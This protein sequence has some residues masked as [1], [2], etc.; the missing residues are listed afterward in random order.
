MDIEQAIDLSK[1]FLKIDTENLEPYLA[2]QAHLFF[3]FTVAF[4][5]VKKEYEIALAE[6]G[7]TYFRVRE[8]AEKITTK[9]IT[10]KYI[11]A[12]VNSNTEIIEEKRILSNLENQMEV[13]KGLLK[14]LE[15]RRDMIVQLSS[16]KRAETKLVG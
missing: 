8:E 6:S 11:E 1:H 12:Y 4:T 14:S 3:F 16:N 9:K 5:K 7:R 2:N 15:H 13:L 10:E